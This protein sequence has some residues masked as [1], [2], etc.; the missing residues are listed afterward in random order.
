MLL[1][2]ISSDLTDLYDSTVGFSLP[3]FLVLSENGDE[4]L[5]DLVLPNLLSRSGA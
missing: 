3:P 2:V 4:G 5:L 1:S